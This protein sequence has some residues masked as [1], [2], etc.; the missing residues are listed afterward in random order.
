MLGS[1]TDSQSSNI[2]SGLSPQQTTPSESADSFMAQLTSALEGYLAKSGNNS[3]LEID[4]Q[5]TQSQ[6]SGVSQFL[7]TVKNP[8]SA[9]A[10]AG[11]AASILPPAAATAAPADRLTSASATARETAGRQ[12]PLAETPSTISTPVNTLPAFPAFSPTSIY[13]PS[14]SPK[15]PGATTASLDSFLSC[16]ARGFY[17]ETSQENGTAMGDPTAALTELANNYVAQNPGVG[18][19][20]DIQSLVSKY[21]GQY[22]TWAQQYQSY[23]KAAGSSR[24]TPLQGQGSAAVV[25]S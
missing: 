5:S 6:N 24:V 13:V 8:N 12:A 23:M 25:I 11:T 22:N 4:V 21:A 14:S 7:V 15:F 2:L 16:Q 19:Q 20:A 9:S 1:V 10:P 17:N 3:N 18:S